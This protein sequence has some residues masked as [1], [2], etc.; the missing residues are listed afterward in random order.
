MMHL[1]A[2]RAALA[3]LVPAFMAGVIAGNPLLGFYL[4]AIAAAGL[5]GAA[6]LAYLEAVD[7]TRPLELYE[8]GAIALAALLMMLEVAIRFPRALS[9]GSEGFSTLVLLSGLLVVSA[10]GGRAAGPPRARP[11]PAQPHPAARADFSL[12]RT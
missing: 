1:T 2:P 9:A 4:T 3:S 8:L 12:G 5:I 10:G 6:F 7:R 11:A